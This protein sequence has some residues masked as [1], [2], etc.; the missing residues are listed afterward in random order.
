MI[1]F[2]RNTTAITYLFF[3][4]VIQTTSFINTQIIDIKEEKDLA[5]IF[6]SKHDTIIMGTS[7]HCHWC[8]QTKPHFT[9]LEEQF[10]AKIKFY[11]VN[12]YSSKLQSFLHDFTHKG[13]HIT[14]KLMKKLK[15]QNAVGP[16]DTLQIP[17]YP[18]FLYLKHGKIVDIHI[19]GCPLVT[20]EKFIEKNHKQP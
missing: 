11:I 16:H 5:A 1:F 18:T 13:N 14:E 4:L 15:N 17:G 6:K 2:Q 8:I 7:D 9:Q 3:F 10:G 20:L 19:G 12:G